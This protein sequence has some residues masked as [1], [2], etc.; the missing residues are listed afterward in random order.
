MHIRVSAQKAFTIFLK[1][2]GMA[3]IANSAWMALSAHHWFMNI[4]A[5]L[6]ATGTANLHFIHDVAAAYFTFGVGLIWC[7]SNIEKAYPV[8]LG[9]TLVMVAHGLS[10]VLEIIT[11]QLPHSHWLIDLP[12]VFIPGFFMAILAWPTVWQKLTTPRAA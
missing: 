9:A 8:Y 4:P 5:D 12:L 1:V 7:S 3:M 6:T 10:H 2:A 11:G